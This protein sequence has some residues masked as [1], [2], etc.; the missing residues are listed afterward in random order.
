MLDLETA[1]LHYD[2]L[3]CLCV[4]VCLSAS[5]S[6]E[7]LDRSSPNFCADP[8]WLGPPLV[9]LRYVTYFRFMDDVTFDRNGP[10]DDAKPGRCLMSMNALLANCVV[11]VHVALSEFCDY[12]VNHNAKQH[13]FALCII[14]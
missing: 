9:A 4:S 11:D 2:Q 8:L 1:D 7:P 13:F 12:H 5:I 10:Y 3:V 14:L 6:L